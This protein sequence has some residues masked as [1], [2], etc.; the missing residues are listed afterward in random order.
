MSLTAIELLPQLPD[1]GAGRWWIGFSGGLDSTVL[2]HLL[3]TLSRQQ[4]IPAVH[5]VHINHRMNPLADQWQAH[6]E[7][8]CQD[9][10]VPLKV[11]RVSVQADGHGVEAAARSARYGVFEHCLAATDCL[12]LA[13]HR[14]DQVETFFLRLLR[15][16]G[17]RGLAGM[18]AHRPL[19][20][21]WLYRPLLGYCRAELE[22]YAS[23]H[24]LQWIEDG[25]NMDITFDR[26]YLRHEVLPRLQQRWPAYRDTVGRAMETVAEADRLLQVHGSRELEQAR[27]EYF[28]EPTLDRRLL[29]NADPAGA[30]WL[31][32][33][34]L[35]ELGL[36]MPTRDCLREFLQQLRDSHSGARPCMQGTG[37]ELRGYRDRVHLLCPPSPQLGATSSWS[38][39]P[40]RVLEIDGIGRVEMCAAA[41]GLSLPASGAWS[42]T[43]RQ[44]GERCRPQGRAHSQSLK[45]LL[46]EHEVPPWWRSR[47]PLLY[48]GRDMVAVADLWLCEGAPLTA[49]GWLLRWE[50]DSIA[51]PR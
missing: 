4:A 42:V 43:L 34:W 26:N 3:A 1:P 49:E 24:K 37:Y 15:G 17:T 12:L 8:V 45:K 23:L 47:L 10:D 48:S 22:H 16:A 5:A 2:L 46:Q 20:A 32:R 7:R 40:G 38:L 19:G 28:G 35:A 51:L 36:P 30:S 44:G 9:L 29:D 21:G 27:G 33:Q 50:R 11:H 18:P 6:C 39:V 14:D 25:S 41:G 13:H 31:L